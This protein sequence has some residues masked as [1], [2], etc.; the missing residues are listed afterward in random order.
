MKRFIA[1]VK[2]TSGI[3][4]DIVAPYAAREAERFKQLFDSG[5]IYEYY[6]QVDAGNFWLIIHSPSL[7]EAQAQLE[8]FPYYGLGYISFDL[9]ELAENTLTR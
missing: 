4:D 3:T 9:T 5:L 6:K 7:E 2:R 1:E 8:T